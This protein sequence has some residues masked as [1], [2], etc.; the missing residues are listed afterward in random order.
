M[1]IFH[2]GCLEGNGALEHRVENNSQTPRICEEAFIAFIRD[3]LW[4]DVCWCST[5][6]LDELMLLN[7]LGHSEITQFDSFLIIE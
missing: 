1:K 4:S 3:D 5:L 7:D 2:V 6:L